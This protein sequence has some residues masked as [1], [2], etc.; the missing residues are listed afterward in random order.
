MLRRFWESR[1]GNYAVVFSIAIIPVMVAVAGAVDTVYTL[2]KADQ[3]QSSLDTAAL[4]IATKYDPSMTSEEFAGIGRDFFDANMVGIN[5]DADELAFETN[6]PEFTASASVQAG[7]HFIKVSSGIDHDGM[8]RSINWKVN[9]E[10]VVRIKDGPPACVLALDPHGAAAIKLQG[11]TNVQLAGCVIAANSDSSSAVSRG[12]S[13]QLTAECVHTVGATSGINGTSNVNLEC[14]AALENQY[15]SY[16]PLSGITPPSK[17]GCPSAR[18]PSGNN[19]KT[20]SP[21]TYCNETFS[22]DITLQPGVYVLRGGEIK[23]NGNGRLVGSGVTI[24]LMEDAELSIQANQTIQL[25]PPTTGPYAGITIYQER[26]NHT[27]LTINGTADSVVTG[28]VYAPGAHVFYAGNS[29]TTA[30]PGCLRMVGN[31]IELTGNS[32]MTS[33]CSGQL[34][35]RTMFAGRYMTLVR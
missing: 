3:L 24:F 23:L 27:T 30:T 15:P 22:G 11:S 32:A 33:N 4:A 5:Q 28:F 31:T 19:A 14:Q 2:N 1:S 35:G 20:L 12:G 13:A 17:V 25:S 29:A 21:G 10:S 26:S 9:R 16:D 6:P 8:I 7:E 34:G 18:V